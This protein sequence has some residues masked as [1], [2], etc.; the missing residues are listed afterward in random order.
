MSKETTKKTA[1]RQ[2]AGVK[3]ELR[4]QYS[5]D[6]SKSRPNRFAKVAAEGCRMIVLE[7]DVAAV[8]KT[9]DA[10]NS[11]LRALISTMPSGS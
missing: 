3:D 11:V 4:R 9:P 2:P 7:P 6:Y 5:F 10:V 8:F 1:K